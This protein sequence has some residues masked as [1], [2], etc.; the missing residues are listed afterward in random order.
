MTNKKKPSDKRAPPSFLPYVTE[1]DG[2]GRLIR[3]A[4]DEASGQDDSASRADR[5]SVDAVQK[6]SAMHDPAQSNAELLNRHLDVEIT[7]GDGLAAATSPPSGHRW[8]AESP[9]LEATS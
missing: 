8:I 3:P 7:A 4:Q 9:F 1:R 5:R 6:A 2:L